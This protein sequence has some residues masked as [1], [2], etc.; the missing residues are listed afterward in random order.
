MVKGVTGTNSPSPLLP[1][2]HMNMASRPVEHGETVMPSVHAVGDALVGTGDQG[3][4]VD[5]VW[6]AQGHARTDDDEPASNITE[7]AMTSPQWANAS[8]VS[9]S[10]TRPIVLPSVAH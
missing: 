4:A 8:C 9:L 2:S 7:T 6:A 10:A 3:A 1:S 5:D